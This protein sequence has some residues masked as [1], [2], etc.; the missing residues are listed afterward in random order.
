M[1]ELLESFKAPL[2]VDLNRVQING[3]DALFSYIAKLQMFFESLMM[4]YR[5][6][7]NISGWKTDAHH[8]DIFE[9]HLR[10][11]MHTVNL[12][13]L[14][15]G[16]HP[17]KTLE[18]DSTH[19]M[20]MHA[21]E[22]DGLIADFRQR[23]EQLE[24]LQT[25]EQQISE[26]LAY[27][28]AHKKD[29]TEEHLR[30][31]C[32]RVYWESLIPNQTF[33]PLT[34]GDLIQ[35]RDTGDHRVYYFSWAL[36]NRVDNR[37]YFNIMLLEQDMKEQP[38]HESEEAR[39]L[40]FDAVATFGSQE[41]PLHYMGVNIDTE[42]KTIHPIYLYR[43]GIGPFYTEAFTQ[44]NAGVLTSAFEHVPEQDR[45]MLCLS[46]EYLESKDRQDS[47]LS[48]LRGRVREVYRIAEHDHEAK[49]RKATAVHKSL[50]L[51]HSLAGHLD[52]KFR[53]HTK[54]YL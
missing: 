15:Y 36:F 28:F 35:L 42:L 54:I 52:N 11:I 21:G 40:F 8:V 53:T 48:I 32:E 16:Y 1:Q 23:P 51:P 50:L 29:V 27:I 22:L 7:A 2:K 18:Y 31:L 9:S 43:V 34:M 41:V 47:F 13:R 12:L 45:F 33:L 4:R 49:T 24:R 25:T 3:T 37:P 30:N 10:R 39:R 6:I 44:N 20:F 19:S 14:K 38:L 26:M 17:D 5:D 46:E